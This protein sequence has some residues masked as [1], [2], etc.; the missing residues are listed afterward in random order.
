MSLCADAIE[1]ACEKYLGWEPNISLRAGLEKTY[2]WIYD[3][4]Q[5][6]ERGAEGVVHEIENR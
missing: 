2:A 4:Y 6:R 5:L 3:Q 1:E